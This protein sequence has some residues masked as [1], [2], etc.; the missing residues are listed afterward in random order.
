MDNYE[1]TVGRFRKF[2]AGYPANKPVLKAG[3]NPNNPSDTGWD[4]FWNAQLPT[5]NASLLV[6]ISCG[7]ATNHTWTPTPD[8]FENYP[9][10][11]ID[12]YLAQSFCIW[13]GGRLP[14]EAEWNY[15][16]AGGSEQRVY[17]WSSP[18]DSTTI[19]ETYASYYDGNG[20]GGGDPSCVPV[21]NIIMVGSRPKG[22]GRWGHSDLAGNLAE[23]IGDWFYAFDNPCINCTNGKPDNGWRPM[24]GGSF[25][26]ADYTL[27]TMTRQEPLGT[28]AGGGMRCVRLP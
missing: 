4:D 10:N 11:C 16:A 6:K 22:N 5:D 12:W 28:G 20:C 15:A 2:V 21:Y 14:T 19:D 1:V 17:P 25:D 24:H 18:P 26:A 8:A 13:D 23:W 9:M 7:N 27:Q 3:R